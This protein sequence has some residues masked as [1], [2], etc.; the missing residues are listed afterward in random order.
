MSAID[1]SLPRVARP[2]LA[3]MRLLGTAR[4]AIGVFLS[5]FR[6]LLR[7]RPAQPVVMIAWIVILG[8]LGIGNVID[9][10]HWRHLYMLVGIVWGCGALEQKYQR[11]LSGREAP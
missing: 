10:D 2:Q 6:S 1:L 4:V 7:E 3:T 11:S 8:H 9:T 5:G